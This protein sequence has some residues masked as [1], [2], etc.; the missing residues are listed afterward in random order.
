MMKTNDRVKR[1]Y[2]AGDLKWF[3]LVYS[4]CSGLIVQSRR[5]KLITSMLVWLWILQNPLRVTVEI[6]YDVLRIIFLR[7][8]NCAP[9]FR[10]SLFSLLIVMTNFY[11]VRVNWL[12]SWITS[13]WTSTQT[14]KHHLL[15]TAGQQTIHDILVMLMKTSESTQCSGTANKTQSKDAEWFRPVFF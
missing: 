10:I 1:W 12:I 3:Y 8:S 13:F 5:S 15:S 14:Y 4:G 7:L 11:S 2:S 6:K 9:R